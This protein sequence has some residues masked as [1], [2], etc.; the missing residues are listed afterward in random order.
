[1]SYTFDAPFGNEI[2][3]IVIS[4]PNG[5]GFQYNL[6]IDSYFNGQIVKM[7]DGWHVYFNSNQFTSADADALLELMSAQ[8]LLDDL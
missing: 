7:M 1:M 4:R 6:M 3:T 2:K 5:A 8:N